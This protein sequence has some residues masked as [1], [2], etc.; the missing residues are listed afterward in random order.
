MKIIFSILSLFLCHSQQIDPIPLFPDGMAYGASVSTNYTL[1]VFWDH[2]CPY[3]ASAFNGLF[4]YYYNTPW[5]R[6]VIH[7]L[8][9]PYHYYAFNVGAAGRY[10]QSNTPSTFTQY[11]SYMFKNQNKYLTTAQSWNQTTLFSNL[12]NDTQ[13]ATGVD[14]GL[15]L[16]S[17]KNGTDALNL[18]ISWKYAMSKGITGTPT[19]MLNGVLV[20]QATSF[21]SVTDW[22]NFF[23]SL[24]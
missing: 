5:L 22:E 18:R 16:A 2:L 17:L 1:D 20:P 3:S 21:T 14:A 9:L 13:T 19:Y 12:A 24:N 23:S 8:P 4:L 7:I 10:V 15:V 6:M 11:L